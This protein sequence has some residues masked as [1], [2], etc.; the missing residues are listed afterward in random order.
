M[1]DVSRL[2]QARAGH[3]VKRKL[4][5]NGSHVTFNAPRECGMFG[6]IV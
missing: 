2:Y 5:I 6:G 3:F 4:T 1:V